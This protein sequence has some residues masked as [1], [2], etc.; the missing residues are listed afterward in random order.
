ME[1]SEEAALSYLL[2]ELFVQLPRFL[3]GQTMDSISTLAEA[4]LV[5]SNRKPRFHLGFFQIQYGF[6]ITTLES[7]TLHVWKLIGLRSE[8]DIHTFQAL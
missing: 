8:I 5:Y 2:F 3:L 4:N 1:E 6:A 7:V